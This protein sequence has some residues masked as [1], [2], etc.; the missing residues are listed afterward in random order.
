MAKRES[1]WKLAFPSYVLNLYL[2][3]DVVPDAKVPPAQ[4]P[5]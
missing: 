1:G 3:F 4:P 5:K 2:F